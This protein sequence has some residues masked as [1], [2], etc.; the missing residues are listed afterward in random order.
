MAKKNPRIGRSADE[1]IV[2]QRAKDPEFRP[3]SIGCKSHAR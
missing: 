2:E 3:S 1:F